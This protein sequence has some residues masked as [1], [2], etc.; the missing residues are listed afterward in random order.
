MT[1]LK[2]Y[3]NYKE[4]AKRIKS[5]DKVFYSDEE[6][7][8]LLDESIGTTDYQFSLLK[9]IAYILDEFDINLIRSE[10]EF[11]GKGY[12]KATSMECVEVTT[13]RLQKR[14]H[15]ASNK[16]R[17]VLSLVEPHKLTEVTKAI[18]DGY[19]IK[20]GLLQS[21]LSQTPLSKCVEGVA[22]RL[23]LPKLIL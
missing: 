9:L 21:F 19:V 23:D 7:S 15:N 17:K 3:P 6:M 1:E 12:K 14:I 18:Y 13:P 4:A 20:N 10:N 22:V 16:Q 11:S 2:L 5:D 8:L